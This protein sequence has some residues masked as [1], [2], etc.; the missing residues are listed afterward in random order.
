MQLHFMYKTLEF[1]FQ[2][3]I[4]EKFFFQISTILEVSTFLEE[5]GNG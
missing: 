5:A 3:T 4:L 2:I 1:V